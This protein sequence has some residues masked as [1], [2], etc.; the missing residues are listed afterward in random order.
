M[1]QQQAQSRNYSIYRIRGNLNVFKNVP[2]DLIG[3]DQD[4]RD[5]L[6]ALIRNLEVA[7]NTTSAINRKYTFYCSSHIPSNPIGL[8]KTTRNT[9]AACIVCGSTH[10]LSPLFYIRKETYASTDQ[11]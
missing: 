7:I 6:S 5:T 3:F 4:S 8:I 2:T 11:S 9:K 1:T 10:Y